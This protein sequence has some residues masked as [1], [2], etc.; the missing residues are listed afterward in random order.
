MENKK[1]TAPAKPDKKQTSKKQVALIGF[2]KARSLLEKVITMT[3]K[4]EYCIDIMQ[5]NMAA[6][7]LLKSA[8]QKLMENHLSTCFKHAM[9]KKDEKTKIKM[10]EEILKVSKLSNK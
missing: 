9:D 5:Q 4:G 3:E 6:I 8:H 10:I 7:G 1:T 2:K